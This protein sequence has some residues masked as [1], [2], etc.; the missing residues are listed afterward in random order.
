M[1]NSTKTVFVG[2]SLSVLSVCNVS[3]DSF[4]TTVD[5]TRQQTPVTVSQV[6]AMVLP[7]VT[8]DKQVKNGRVLCSTNGQRPGIEKKYCSG[9]GRNAIFVIT[10]RPQTAL[11]IDLSYDN[12]NQNGLSF[13]AQTTDKK[14]N[15]NKRMFNAN[16][17]YTLEV[18]GELTLVDKDQVTDEILVFDFDL[19]AVYN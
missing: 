10:G 17:T 15:S 11:N 1:K 18:A 7:L 6:Q 19:T 4:S 3:A 9:T 8:V 5:V 2:L 16:G 12:T 14:G 13:S